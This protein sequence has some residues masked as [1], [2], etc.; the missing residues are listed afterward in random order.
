EGP[1]GQR[2]LPA[3]ADG[4]AVQLVLLFLLPRRTARCV[5][6]PLGGL[7]DRVRA[8]GPRYRAARAARLSAGQEAARAGEDHRFAQAGAHRAARR[9]RPAGARRARR[10]DQ[11]HELSVSA[12]PPDPSTVRYEGP[13]THRDVHANGIRF[14]IVEAAPG[15]AATSP[16]AP[17]VLLLHGF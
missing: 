11:A 13:W 10:A 2:L 3:R 5:A 4:A 16:D 9:P 12:N 6:G 14:H 8:D 17:L 7:P 15:F 1:A